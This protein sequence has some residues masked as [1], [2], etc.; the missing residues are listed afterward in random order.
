[1]VLFERGSTLDARGN[2]PAWTRESCRM[3]AG[4]VLLGRGGAGWPAGM[5]LLG[6]GSVQDDRGSGPAW[7][8]ERAG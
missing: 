2:G 8:R 5:V 4:M 7:T 1:M 3:T 6:R